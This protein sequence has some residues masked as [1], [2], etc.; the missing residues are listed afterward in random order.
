MSNCSRYAANLNMK[1]V[2]VFNHPVYKKVNL[3]KFKLAIE[4]DSTDCFE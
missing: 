4:F 1:A 2:S 3:F